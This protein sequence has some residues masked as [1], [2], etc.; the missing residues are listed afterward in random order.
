M[1]VAHQDDRESEYITV[2]SG[3]GIGKAEQLV[4]AVHEVLGVRW[5]VP[6]ATIY[7]PLAAYEEQGH[8][9]IFVHP[10]SLKVNKSRRMIEISAC[11]PVVEACL[12][13]LQIEGALRNLAIE[14]RQGMYSKYLVLIK[15]R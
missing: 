6:N 1:A 13:H 5:Q 4:K 2:E 14:K 3:I 15:R 10:A 8:P 9:G 7:D 12:V 11:G